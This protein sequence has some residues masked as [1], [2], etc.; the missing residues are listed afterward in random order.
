[1]NMLRWNGHRHN[2]KGTKKVP[3]VLQVKLLFMVQFFSL[4]YLSSPFLLLCVCVFDIPC[5]VCFCLFFK[6][7]VMCD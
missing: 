5:V 1:M 7:L 3:S 6:L 4:N 2:M